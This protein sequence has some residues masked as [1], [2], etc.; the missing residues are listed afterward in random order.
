MGIRTIPLSDLET[1]LT[2]TLTDCARSGDTVVVQMPDDRLLAIHT[3]D[4]TDAADD[5]LVN[6][7]IEHNPAFRAMLARSNQGTP[8]PFPFD[9]DL[10]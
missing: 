9:P 10:E 2:A 3:L 5:D 7:L 1:D 6:D 4:P 8:E